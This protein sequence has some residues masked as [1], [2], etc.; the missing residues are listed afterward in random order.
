MSND[1][2][3]RVKE[4]EESGSVFW[5]Q[6]RDGGSA[7]RRRRRRIRD[8]GCELEAKDRDPGDVAHPRARVRGQLGPLDLDG[9]GR[10]LRELEVG[11][12]SDVPGVRL[13]KQPEETR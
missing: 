5:L 3:L 12:D 7:R 6:E 8:S 10:D 11:R 1:E 4:P 13:R 9:E 2:L